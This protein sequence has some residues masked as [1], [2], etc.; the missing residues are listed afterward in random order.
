MGD[1][2]KLQVAALGDRLAS[3]DGQLRMASANKIVIPVVKNNDEL[4]YDELQ[5]G[6]E[7]YY[8]PGAWNSS[9]KSYISV[10]INKIEVMRVGFRNLSNLGVSRCLAFKEK[11]AAKI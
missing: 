10:T 2:F 3:C 7:L 6:F 8:F 9:S 1:T 11:R 5:L 4:A